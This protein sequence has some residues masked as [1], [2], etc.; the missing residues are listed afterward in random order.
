MLLRGAKCKCTFK[1]NYHQ[2]KENNV[3]LNNIQNKTTATKR[4]FPT[5]KKILKWSTRRAGD[6][7]FWTMLK[8]N[9]DQR[10]LPTFCFE[11]DTELKQCPRSMVEV[12]DKEI[13]PQK[14]RDHSSSLGNLWIY[15]AMLICSA[16]FMGPKVSW[17]PIYG[18]AFHKLMT[19]YWK[20]ETG[21]D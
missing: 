10:P 7:I 1:E 4:I 8:L 3:F 13:A 17:G 16:S 20:S 12:A 14:G 21:G 2:L 11:I 15:L 6:T 9:S 19:C 5:S 18:V